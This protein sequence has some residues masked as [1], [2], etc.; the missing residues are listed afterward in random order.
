VQLQIKRFKEYTIGSSTHTAGEENKENAASHVKMAQRVCASPTRRRTCVELTRLGVV[1]TG[2]PGKR[3]RSCCKTCIGNV[4]A[5]I[6]HLMKNAMF[7]VGEHA[8]YKL[9]KA[10]GI[11]RERFQGDILR[12]PGGPRSCPCTPSLHS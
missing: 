2:T 10:K 3:L 6:A 9:K 1:P 12:I 7:E 4:R 11:D 5:T 8:L